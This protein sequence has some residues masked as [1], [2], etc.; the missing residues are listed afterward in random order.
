MRLPMRLPMRF[1]WNKHAHHG[2]GRQ[3]GQLS[4]AIVGA[5]SKQ[6]LRLSELLS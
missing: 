1:E 4:F 5:V 6:Q 3:I 2:G